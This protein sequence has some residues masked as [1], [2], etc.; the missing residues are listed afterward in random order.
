MMAKA[1]DIVNTAN[2][3]M[4]HHHVIRDGSVWLCTHCRATWP[5]PQP[6]PEPTTACVPRRWSE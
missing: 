4:T 5:Y 1:D 2:A 6:L 3:T